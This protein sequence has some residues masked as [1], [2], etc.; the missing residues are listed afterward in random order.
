[1]TTQLPTPNAEQQVAYFSFP[2]IRKEYTP[3]GHLVVYGKAT[4]GTVDNDRQIV[5]PT[6]SGKALTEWFET[7]PNIRVQHSPALYPAGKGLELEVDKDG[8]GGHWVKGLVVEDTAKKLVEEKVLRAYSVGIMHPQ[9]I[10]DAQAPGGRIVGGQ[11]AEISLVDRPANKNCGFQLAKSAAGGGPEFVG[12]LWGSVE[13][14]KAVW[15]EAAHPRNPAGSATGGEFTIAA[16][17]GSGKKP[18]AKPASKPASQHRRMAYDPARGVGPGYNMP[19]GDPQVK[20]LQ[21]LLNK[22]GLTDSHGRKLDVDGKLGPLTTQSI[23]AAQ[24]RLGLKEDGVVTSGFLA[25]LRSHKGKL[26]GSSHHTARHRGSSR[27]RRKEQDKKPASRE[28]PRPQPAKTNEVVISDSRSGHTVMSGK[29]FVEQLELLAKAGPSGYRHGWSYEGGPGLP[30]HKPRRRRPRTAGDLFDPADHDQM[31]R[32]LVPEH[33]HAAPGEKGAGMA[34]VI[35][36]ADVARVINKRDIPQSERD[37]M[38]SSD[39]AGRGT[40]FPIRKPED[41]AAAFHS[42]GR[43][44][45]D[46]YDTATIRRNIIRIA[47]RKGFPL[48]ESARD[49]HSVKTADGVVAKGAKDC[50]DCGHTYHAD[51]SMRNCENCGRKLPAADTAKGADGKPFA[52]A[53]KPFGKADDEKMDDSDVD[54]DDEDDEDEEP[55]EAAEKSAS[56]GDGVEA[57]ETKPVGRHREPDGAQAA[58]FEQDAG[59]PVQGERAGTGVPGS[60]WDTTSSNTGEPASLKGAGAEDG[61]SYALARLHDLVCAAHDPEVVTLAYPA[62]KGLTH[63]IAQAW[64][65]LSDDEQA[66]VKG[67]PDIDE[68]LLAD[69]Q[70]SLFK[71]FAEMYPNVHITPG[72]IQPGQFRRPYL[73]TG[74]PALSAASPAHMPGPADAEGMPAGARS[75]G[76]IDPGQFRRGYLADGHARQ[77]P[78]GNASSPMSAKSF[79]S[80]AL[81]ALH[82]S[83]AEDFPGLCA[84]AEGDTIEVSVHKGE[85]LVEPG[86][87]GRITELEDKI[88]KMQGDHAREIGDLRQLVE[89]MSA[90]PDPA[91]APVRGV[92]TKG[93]GPADRVSRVDAALD[94]EE[95]RRRFAAQFT[96][97]GDPQMRE[98]ARRYQQG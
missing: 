63:G 98:A 36:P 60:D 15:D 35:T 57:K 74:H 50:P 83:I 25:A 6:W 32:R 14:A 9:I 76:G 4:D 93:A 92:L 42:L 48:P 34:S 59:L 81:A 30:V 64:D 44:G 55:E 86:D 91:A 61:P 3:E 19:H 66:L 31:L 89:R 47:R 38:P 13:A 49:E 68:A 85:Y 54:K 53:A 17:G 82:D 94:Q 58:A 20:D 45:A 28:R 11:I 88:T 18:A 69:A 29:A 39:F 2:I 23:K 71:A 80:G 52:G 78:T 62:L 96:F 67:L 24:R 16:Q 43:A 72:S 12:K 8:S 5:D 77:S 46:N 75:F 22:L 10:R 95:Q 70:T 84:L 40:S 33:A 79:T 21:E 37:D 27:R 26:R 65:D 41:V 56:P 87:S 7:G 90:E 1:M 73:S 97:S 51:S